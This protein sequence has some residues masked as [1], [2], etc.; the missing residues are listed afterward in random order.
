[1][2]LLNVLAKSKSVKSITSGLRHTL[3]ELKNH[4][5]EQEASATAALIVAELA[6][7]EATTASAV[8]KNLENLLGTNI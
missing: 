7:E 3:N 1:M 5:A 8:V 6:T 2:N 4:Q